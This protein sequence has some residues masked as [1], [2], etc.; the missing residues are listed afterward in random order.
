MNMKSMSDLGQAPET[1]SLLPC[2]L[3]LGQMKLLRQLRHAKLIDCRP[4]LFHLPTLMSMEWRMS[5]Q[6]LKR[7]RK[8]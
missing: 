8:E 5:R 7:R 2:P 3:T 1:W 6:E 4:V